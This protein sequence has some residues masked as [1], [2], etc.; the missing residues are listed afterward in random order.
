MQRTNA[1]G[2]FALACAMAA[3]TLWPEPA[4]ATLN[5]ADSASAFP[6]ALLSYH[7]A[8]QGVFERLINRIKANPFNLAGTVIFFLAIVHTFLSSRFIALSHDLARA[9]AERI[10]KGSAPLNSVS[11]GARVLYFFGEIEVVF[12]LWAVVLMLT[13]ALFFDPQTA[14]HYVSQTVNFTEAMFVVVI[15]TLAAT[16]PILKLAEALMNQAAQAFGGSLTAWWLSILTLGPLL[17]S[18][19]RH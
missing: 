17:D 5:S 11:Q 2:Y 1:L 14:V 15:M 16:R 18:L 7:D 4:A 19:M 9:H 3:I 10:E 8:G 12:G 6:Q 13:I